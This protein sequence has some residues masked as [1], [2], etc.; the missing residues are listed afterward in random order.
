MMLASWADGPG[1]GDDTGL[2]KRYPVS[3]TV[4][5]NGTPLEKGQISFIATDKNK[6]R[7]ANGFIQAGRYTLTTATPED[8]PCPAST[9]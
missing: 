9:A 6:Q 5:Y 7:D 4:T 1:C 8:A 3:G 2:G